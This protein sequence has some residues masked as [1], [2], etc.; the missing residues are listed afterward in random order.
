MYMKIF[1]VI[2]AFNEEKTVGE[3]VKKVKS[4]VDNIV[5]V[6]DGSSDRTAEIASAA[7]AVVL[8]HPLN[9][10]QGAALETGN[11][12]ALARA[13][14]II[15]HFDADNQFSAEDIPA[16]LEPLIK[17]E[18]E[19]VLG[20]RFLGKESNMPAFKKKVIMPMAHLVNKFLLGA[21]LSDPQCGFRALTAE[22]WRKISIKQDGMAHASEILSK[23]IRNKI[24]VKEVPIKVIYHRAGQGFLGG[25]GSGSGGIRIVK[26]IILAKLMD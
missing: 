26:D 2:P 8:R 24:R 25:R 22:A 6:D 1:C 23:I 20:S 15:F 3:V 7:G 14:D 19:A 13:A 5:V 9:R 18:A 17:G 16:V 12:Y 11:Q 21:E 4:L 10:G